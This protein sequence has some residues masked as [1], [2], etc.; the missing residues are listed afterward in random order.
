MEKA[1]ITSNN[2]GKR[3]KA[4]VWKKLPEHIHY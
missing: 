2:K 1:A 3:N 4:K